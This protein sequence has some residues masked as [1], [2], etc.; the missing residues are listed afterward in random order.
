MKYLLSIFLALSSLANAAVLAVVDEILPITD[1]FMGSRLTNVGNHNSLYPDASLGLAVNCHPYDPTTVKGSDM[2]AC[3]AHPLIVSY[4]QKQSCKFLPEPIQ[5]ILVALEPSTKVYL[6]VQD[7][8]WNGTPI[9]VRAHAF[10]DFFP[11]MGAEYKAV[12]VLVYRDDGTMILNEAGSVHL[13][14]GIASPDNFVIPGLDHAKNESFYSVVSYN[15]KSVLTRHILLT[16]EA[17]EQFQDRF[18]VKTAEDH[19]AAFFARFLGDN[20]PKFL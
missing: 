7:N 20:Y 1:T 15:G 3:P 8:P 2:P 14:D 12:N 11:D 6:N 17:R 13:H 5:K 19:S 4:T 16:V 18:C 10:L 9:E